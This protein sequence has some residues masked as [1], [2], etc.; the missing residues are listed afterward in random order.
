MVLHLCIIPKLLHKFRLIL[1]LMRGIFEGLMRFYA[2]VALGISVSR[3][4]SI[5]IRGFWNNQTGLIWD[6]F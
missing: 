3:T 4:F 2:D 1:G 6:Y 5:F